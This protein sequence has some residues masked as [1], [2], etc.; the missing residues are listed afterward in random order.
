MDAFE[1]YV[2]ACRFEMEMREKYRRK[3]LSKEHQL[4]LESIPGWT[5]TGSFLEYP[6]VPNHKDINDALLWLDCAQE[7]RCA[8]SNWDTREAAVY[9]QINLKECL[10]AARL[11][12]ATARA[13]AVPRTAAAA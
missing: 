7:E 5:W 10:D 9:A 6:D 3:T 12:L 8:D 2:S 1:A 13:P 11:F 4:Q